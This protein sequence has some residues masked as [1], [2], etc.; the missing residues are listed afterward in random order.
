[1]GQVQDVHRNHGISRASRRRYRCRFPRS[2]SHFSERPEDQSNS[3]VNS[4]NA[5][6]RGVAR[7]LQGSAK[8]QQVNAT[9]KKHLRS[10]HRRC[11][12]GL[13]CRKGGKELIASFRTSLCVPGR[14][15]SSYFRQRL[16]QMLLSTNPSHL[17]HRHFRRLPRRRCSALPFHP[18]HVHQ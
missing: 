1:M 13:E 8:M 10:V 4:K 12:V 6:N 14:L 5:S 3:Q 2:K 18:I 15:R 11:F 17:R 9:Q 7:K 16:K